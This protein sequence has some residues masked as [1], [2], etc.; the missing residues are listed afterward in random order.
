MRG[1]FAR[2]PLY[3][4]ACITIQSAFPTIKTGN[5]VKSAQGQ[6]T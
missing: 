5:A 3:Q 4:P 1:N 6:D 2:C